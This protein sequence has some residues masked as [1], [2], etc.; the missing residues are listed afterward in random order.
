[1][2]EGRTGLNRVG[3]R[4][5]THE[6]NAAQ[7]ELGEMAERCG[8]LARDTALREQA[9]DLAQGAVDAGGGGEIAGGGKEFGKVESP[10]FAAVGR[11]AEELFFAVGVV[12]AERGM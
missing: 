4:L 1:M 6:G 10:G 3:G 8:F 7:Q 2:G 12:D 11:V 5:G 9:K